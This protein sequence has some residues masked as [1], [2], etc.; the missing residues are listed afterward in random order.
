MDYQG[1]ASIAFFHSYPMSED[2]GRYYV[3]ADGRT[4]TARIDP[5]DGQSKAAT[6]QLV[7]YSTQVGCAELAL[8]VM[9]VYVTEAFE[10]S[11]VNALTENGI[12]SIWFVEN[13]LRYNQEALTVNVDADYIAKY[14]NE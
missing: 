4:L 7:S 12:Y 2:Y 1:A 3:F 5:A 9:P 10:E 11:A 6:R 13:E 14:T 8:C